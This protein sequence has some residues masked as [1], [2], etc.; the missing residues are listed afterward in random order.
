VVVAVGLTL[1]VAPPQSTVPTPWSIAHVVAFEMPLQESVDDCPVVMLAGEA[2]ND[3]IVGPAAGVGLVGVVGLAGGAGVPLTVTVAVRVVLPPAP[4]A[5]SVYVVLVVGLTVALALLHETAP[6]PLLMEQL[7]ALPMPVHE[8]VDDCPLVIVAGLAVNAP[9]VGPGG[10]LIVRV[11][12]L[13]VPPAVF[14]VTLCAPASA[15]ESIVRLTVR[16]VLFWTDTEPTV[17]P[18]PLTATV[19]ALLMKLVPASVSVTVLPATAVVGLMAVSVGAGGT[20]VNVMAGLVPP[21]AVV[22]VTAREP[23]DA[24]AAIVSVAAAVVADCTRTSLTVIPLPVITTAAVSPTVKSIPVSV[25][26]TVAPCAPLG[27]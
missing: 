22:R 2:P 18:E 20:T 1:F 10:A 5:V 19:V 8:R 11:C 24:S 14:T 25:T 21:V 6:T 4:L 12:A 17:T 15:D 13:V 27:G 9:I 23:S 16:D 3:P 7:A 26:S